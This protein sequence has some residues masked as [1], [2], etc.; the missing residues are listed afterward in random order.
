[1]NFVCLS[2]VCLPCYSLKLHLHCCGNILIDTRK[3]CIYGVKQHLM[4]V[5]LFCNNLVWKFFFIF[6]SLKKYFIVFVINKF[7]ICFNCSPINIALC[8][9]CHLT[10]K[11]INCTQLF[12]FCTSIKFNYQLCWYNIKAFY[13][14]FFFFSKN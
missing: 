9:P 12:V 14:F 1:M 13:F 10:G 5:C 11:S 3:L 7:I 2:V 6:H 4:L 8:T